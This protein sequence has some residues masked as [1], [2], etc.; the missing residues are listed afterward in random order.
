[1]QL[2]PAVVLLLIVLIQ[3]LR[4]REG[5]ISMNINLEQHHCQEAWRKCWSCTCKAMQYMLYN[6]ASEHLMCWAT[7]GG[8][9]ISADANAAGKCLPAANASTKS[10]LML[11]RS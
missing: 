5:Y 3:L 6:T 8:A 1:M 4:L 7:A 10:R 11:T 2:P 9:A